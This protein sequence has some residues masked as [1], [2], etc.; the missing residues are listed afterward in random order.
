MLLKIN[1]NNIKQV[2]QGSQCANSYPQ[3]ENRI[4]EPKTGAKSRLH[5]NIGTI[6]A[7]RLP[8]PEKTDCARNS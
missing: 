4:A 8:S 6:M 7:C 1:V 2:L 5:Q 3:K